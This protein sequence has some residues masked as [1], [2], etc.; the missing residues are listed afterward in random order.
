MFKI[1][2]S[3]L[4]ATTWNCNIVSFVINCS[5]CV[6]MLDATELSGKHCGYSMRPRVRYQRSLTEQNFKGFLARKKNFGVTFASEKG[7]PF[8]AI[9][10]KLA[11][12]QQNPI[13]FFV[14]MLRTGRGYAVFKIGN[15]LCDMID[16]IFEIFLKLKIALIKIWVVWRTSY[17]VI[18][19]SSEEIQ[20]LQITI[21]IL[22]SD[23]RCQFTMTAIILTVFFLH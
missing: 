4:A 14:K 18:I 9:L 3:F 17:V 21:E 2:V 20:K 13:Q 8:L 19:L 6:G 11:D 5:I 12:A 15:F 16:Q 10:Q 7:L 23:S 22:F 1:M